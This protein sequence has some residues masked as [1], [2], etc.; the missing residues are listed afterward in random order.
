MSSQDSIYFQFSVC[1]ECIGLF[2]G[3]GLH[4]P[5]EMEALK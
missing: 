4:R 1:S 2:H 3:D 5:V